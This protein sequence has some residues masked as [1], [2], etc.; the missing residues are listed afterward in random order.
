VQSNFTVFLLLQNLGNQIV[1]EIPANTLQVGRLCYY[2]ITKKTGTAIS[3]VKIYINGV[4]QTILRST[5]GTLT[6]I[7]NT[8]PFYLGQTSVTAQANFNGVQYALQ[9]YNKELSQAEVT[10]LYE[11]DNRDLTGL[12]ANLVADWRFDENQGG[13]IRDYSPNQLSGTMVNYTVGEQSLGALNKHVN[14]LGSPILF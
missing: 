2:A 11:S 8:N 7:N 5:A 10:Q 4:E 9:I 3:D 13:T 14:Y 12:T 6:T 1:F